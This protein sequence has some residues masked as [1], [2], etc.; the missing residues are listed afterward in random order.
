[1]PHWLQEASKDLQGGSLLPKELI[2]RINRVPSWQMDNAS[3]VPVQV[4][5]SPGGSSMELT[6]NTQS[7]QQGPKQSLRKPPENDTVDSLDQRHDHS[8]VGGV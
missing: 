7:M 2:E 8:T 5:P 6:N 4:Q 1:M 3:P